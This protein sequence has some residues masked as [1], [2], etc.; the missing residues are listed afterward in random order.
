M[1]ND[2]LELVRVADGDLVRLELYQ[3]GLNAAGI[4]S[5]VVGYE[6]GASFGSAIPQSI[7]LWVHRTDA[8]KAAAAIARMESER[9]GPPKD[10]PAFPSTQ[11]RLEAPPQGDARRSPALR[12]RSAPVVLVE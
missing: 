1:A 12:R 9:M 10:R 4:Q 3:Q 11:E 6:L 8:E 5:T 7:Q 2:V